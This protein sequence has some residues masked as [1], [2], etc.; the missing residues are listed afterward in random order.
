MFNIGASSARSNASSVS[1]SDELSLGFQEASSFGEQG[2]SALSTSTGR[3]SADQRIAF[4][5]L[6]RSLYGGAGAAAAGVDT[7][8]ISGS[9]KQLFSGGLGFLETLQGGSDALAARAGDTS[10]RDAQLALLKS[11]LGD[12]FGEEL[13][14]G[15]TDV[16]V[17]TGTLGGARDAVARAQAAKAVGGQ[18]ATGAASI[19]SSDQQRRDTL[20]TEAA[21][22]KQ[23]GAAVGLSSLESLLG[24]SSAGEFAQLSPYEALASIYGGPTVL[25]SSQS[26]DLAQAIS[27]SFG[28]QGSSSYGFDFG[29]AT[30]SSSSQSR[31]KSKS[32]SIGM[33]GGG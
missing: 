23:G 12:F 27:D 1:Q 28:I 10:A 33:G 29:R 2:S 13:M 15:V 16:G 19:I 9:A 26:E 20:A 3:S 24:L 11:Q 25:G 32:F 30:S 8:V 14:P 21:R 18:F 31:S 7:G 22:L 6:F 4:E 5:D 17:A